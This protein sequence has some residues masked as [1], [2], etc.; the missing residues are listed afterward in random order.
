MNQLKRV[1][2]PD[3][4]IGKLAVLEKNEEDSKVYVVWEADKKENTLKLIELDRP[5]DGDIIHLQLDYESIYLL[6][7]I[8]IVERVNQWK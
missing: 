6:N 4:Y 5:M 8:D 7:P 2:N 3:E 1:V